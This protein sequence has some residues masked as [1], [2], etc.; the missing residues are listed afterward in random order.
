MPLDKDI[1]VQEE[2]A[3]AQAVSQAEKAAEQAVKAAQAEKAYLEWKNE[4]DRIYFTFGDD[5]TYMLF[6]LIE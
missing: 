1:V 6:H 2:K 4:K 5:A 3:I